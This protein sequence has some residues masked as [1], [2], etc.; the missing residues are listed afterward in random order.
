MILSFFA[1]LI[2]GLLGW[3][4]SYYLHWTRLPQPSL[5]LDMALDLSRPKPELLIE[6]AFLR[7]QLVTLRVLSIPPI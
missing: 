3:L 2:S 7:Q 4:E 6:N 5:A 1:R